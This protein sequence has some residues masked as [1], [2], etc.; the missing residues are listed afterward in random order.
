MSQLF[1]RSTNTF[2][3]V[4][5]F[6]A[7]FIV[8]GLLAAAGFVARSPYETG[9]GVPIEQPVPFSHKHHVGDDG[10]DCRYCHTSVE[11]SAYAGYPATG[12]CMNCHTQ[13]WAQSPALT[14][15]RES[16]LSGRPIVW[17]RVYD[18]PDFVY[19]DH[20]V[21]VQKGFGCETCHGR[22]DQMPVL[23]KA[24][25]LQMDW[26]LDCHRHPERYIRPREAVLEM[27]WQPSEPQ[28]VLGPRLVRDYAVQ[29]KTSCSTCHR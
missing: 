28:G 17:N 14:P 18:L 19:F 2:S 6:G 15:V 26:C 5:L 1:H 25:T 4:S 24:A 22:V 20:S 9:V 21:H 13:I 16:F 11:T 8:A 29:S 3:R 23:A 27:G 12:I 10:I 7:A